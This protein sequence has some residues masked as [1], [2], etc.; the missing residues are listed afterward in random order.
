MTLAQ[1]TEKALKESAQ[2]VFDRFEKFM[3]ELSDRKAEEL[4][5][6]F[7]DSDEDEKLEVARELMKERRRTQEAFVKCL[8][9]WANSFAKTRQKQA[10]IK[11]W[12]E[13]NMPILKRAE[14]EFH[15]R[16]SDTSQSERV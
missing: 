2:E 14:R 4:L 10:Q 9:D 15:Q 8:S 3:Q 7:L 11:Q 6:K 12:L 5:D 13:E 16:A 1:F